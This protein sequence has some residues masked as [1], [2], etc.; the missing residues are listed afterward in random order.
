MTIDP[1]VNS[2][3]Q[4][5]RS[6]IER[7]K[8]MKAW[9]LLHPHR[10]KFSDHTEFCGLLNLAQVKILP[11]WHFEMLND[12]AR[13]AFFERAIAAAVRPGDVVL[14]IGTGSGLLAMIAARAGA[15]H[16]YACEAN[17]VM[18]ALARQ[19]VEQNGLSEKITVLSK[20]S[21]ALRIGADLPERADVLITETFSELIVGEGVLFAISQAKEHLL[22]PQAVVVPEEVALIGT[23]YEHPDVEDFLRVN[24]GDEICGFDLSALDQ[25]SARGSMLTSVGSLMERRGSAV[26]RVLAAPDIN[27][28]RIDL[29]NDASIRPQ[30]FTGVARHS[31]KIIDAG[32]L[33]TLKV[34]MRLSSH[35][36]AYDVAEE[37]SRGHWR[38]M[39]LSV[40]PDLEV[41]AGDEVELT[42]WRA[43]FP[44][45]GF[46]ADVRLV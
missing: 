40:R 44:G 7:H 36:F 8:Y 14:D 35:G 17:A 46:C 20:H 3:C 5:A 15:A 30:A 34:H 29:Q 21:T 9:Q 33:N 13:N 19:V 26:G 25:I 38:E 11:E 41:R 23:P 10:R 27:L 1:D 45:A 37:G 31:V 12:T 24:G 16:V 39:V 4:Q 2:V 18:A 43:F 42:L 32:C 6:L 28:V 22:K